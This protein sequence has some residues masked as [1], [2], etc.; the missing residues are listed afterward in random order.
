M[1]AP[2][3]A[4]LPT[5]MCRHFNGISFEIAHLSFYVNFASK[6]R[7]K[8]RCWSQMCCYP[9]W[10][11]ATPS[12]SPQSSMNRMAIQALEKMETRKFKAKGKGQRESSCGASDSLS[13]SSTSDCAICL[14]KYIDGEVRRVFYLGY[15][16]I[17]KEWRSYFTSLKLHIG[18]FVGFFGPPSWQTILSINQTFFACSTV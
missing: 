18:F 17:W 14:E 13:S 9:L 16:E 7:A 2:Q 10:H 1:S 6:G 11:C 4:H 15:P 5:V 12:S 8:V 3:N